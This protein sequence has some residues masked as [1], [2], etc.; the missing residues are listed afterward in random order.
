[1]AHS[2]TLNELRTNIVLADTTP[3]EYIW[4]LL[5]TGVFVTGLKVYSQT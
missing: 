3:S 1:M 5:T 4:E 2:H